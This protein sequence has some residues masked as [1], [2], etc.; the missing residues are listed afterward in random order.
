MAYLLGALAV[1]LAACARPAP[2]V[3]HSK[4]LDDEALLALPASGD[5]VSALMLPRWVLG[6]MPRTSE[7]SPS[8]PSV[9]VVADPTSTTEQHVPRSAPFSAGLDAIFDAPL[10]DG[11]FVVADGARGLR[12]VDADAAPG[13]QVSS[14]FELPGWLLDVRAFGDRVLVVT[15]A[16]KEYVVRWLAV[17]RGSAPRLVSE[18]VQS[19][20]ARG[21]Y[22]QRSARGGLRVVV[23]ADAPDATCEQPA[24]TLA[25]VLELRDAPLG[26]LVPAFEAAIA[27]PALRVLRSGDWLMVQTSPANEGDTPIHARFFDL[28]ARG[29]GDA[30]SEPI[31]MGLQVHGFAAPADA[32]RSAPIDIA[33]RSSVFGELERRT[34]TH[35]VQRIRVGARGAVD[36]LAQCEQISHGTP[37]E[38]G[39][40]YSPPLIAQTLFFDSR[41]LLI[42]NDHSVS[43]STRSH[44][45]LVELESCAIRSQELTGQHFFVSPDRALLAGVAPY[46]TSFLHTST[47]AL[48]GLEPLYAFRVELAQS[49]VRELPLPAYDN[50]FVPRHSVFSAAR[51]LSVPFSELDENGVFHDGTQPVVIHEKGQ[52]ELGPRL[53]GRLRARL[54]DGTLV[55]RTE[56]GLL[57][58]A[59]D[60]AAARFID[61]W[62]RYTEAELLEP[63]APG[64]GCALARVRWPAPELRVDARG[65]LLTAQL[66]FVA[67][68]AHP[69]ESTPTATFPI[70]GR[71]RLDHVGRILIATAQ[72][73]VHDI[74]G[75]SWR[76]PCRIEIFDA[77]AVDDVQRVASIKSDDLCTAH[78]P[79]DAQPSFA[80]D[81]GLVFAR[82]AHRYGKPAGQPIGSRIELRV[83]DLHDPSRPAWLP[84]ILT[85]EPEFAVGVLHDAGRLFYAFRLDKVGGSAA[86]PEAHYYLRHVD[87][88][89]PRNPRFGDRISIPGEPTELRGTTLYVR[90]GVWGRDSTGKSFEAHHR[91][92]TLELAEASAR[93][94]AATET[95][96]EAAA[97]ERRVWSTKERSRCAEGS[98]HLDKGV[99]RAQ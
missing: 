11:R 20:Y 79:L 92:L 98:V 83:L 69:Q 4:P 47:Y 51:E 15:N 38:G 65:E 21:V 3:E 36:T 88:R 52:L 76:Q 85:P 30:L 43:N 84:T 8:W 56:H 49:A 24:T 10:G 80:I 28:D 73:L 89:D 33:F 78:R 6:G 68:K 82:T 59:K 63:R 12:V 93:I 42:S 94:V 35:H 60:G 62:P 72:D 14:A 67:A 26:A 90:Q 5:Y 19:G 70:S 37:S 53:D 58:G 66:E 86:L 75:K 87:L 77:R 54:E 13:A 2:A 41:A 23:I 34:D 32:P 61:L 57:F 95:E 7:C 16:Q 81:N 97:L 74:A 29:V 9:E 17:E 31:A 96:L 50:A 22:T 40:I 99:V 27:K 39:G 44:G 45:L 48:P 64:M 25:R 71:A 46:E 18:H 55:Q 91:V 1:L